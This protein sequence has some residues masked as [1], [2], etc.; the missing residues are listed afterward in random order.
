MNAAKRLLT[1]TALGGIAL[2]PFRL[3]R[4]VG[5]FTPKLKYVL[6]WSLKSREYTNLTYELTPENQEYL[7]HT[8]SI[9]TGVTYAR[10]MSYMR[11]IQE[12]VKV[13]QYIVDRIRNSP[14]RHSCDT[15]CAFGRRIGWYAFVRILRPRVV[16]ET[17]VDKGHGAVVLC[18]ALLRNRAEG[19]PGEYFGTDIN[20]KAGFLLDEPYNRVGRVL[21]GDSIESLQT[22]PDIDIFI[23]DS[24]HSELYE[25]REYQTIAPKLGDKGLILGDNCHTNDVLARF[26]AGHDR[27]FLFFREEPAN[28]WYPGAGIGISFSRS[29]IPTS[30]NRDEPTTRLSGE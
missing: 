15:S 30:S 11:E 23:N 27:R 9:V 18:A 19:F 2:I 28:H 26:S 14:M 29:L 7:A 22:V 13:K 5:F 10:A 12:D 8:V 1:Q 3:A 4:A 21:F 17:G 6:S 20:P 16:V 25:E 24:D